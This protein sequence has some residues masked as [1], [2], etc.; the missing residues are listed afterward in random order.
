MTDATDELVVHYRAILAETKCERMYWPVADYTALLSRLEA[1]T[2]RADEWKAAYGQACDDYAAI[3]K[4]TIEQKA[5]N[6][7]LAA[8]LAEARKWSGILNMLDPE[9]AI[10][11]ELLRDL[12]ARLQ[13]HGEKYPDRA[14]PVLHRNVV[15]Y[16]IQASARAWHERN[17]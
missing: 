13:Q 9:N 2:A 11:D 14:V 15:L 17:G 4:Q 7:R 10:D 8:E 16:T 12:H 1:E 3:V 6:A 5:E